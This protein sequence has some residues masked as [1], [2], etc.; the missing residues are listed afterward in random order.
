MNCH[1]YI[2]FL[3]ILFSI[4]TTRLGGMEFG[5]NEATGDTPLHY[6][7]YND[8]TTNII[9]LVQYKN[10]INQPN[11]QGETPLLVAIRSNHALSYAK[12]LIAAGAC[13]NSATNYGMSPLHLAAYLGKLDL[14][15][16]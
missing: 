7:L 9:D 8:N 2:L 12:I 11:H 14:V 5:R 6:S 13:V 1:I 4:S 10:L 16:L 15:N 3:S